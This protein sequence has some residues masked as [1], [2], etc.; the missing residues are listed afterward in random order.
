MYSKLTCKRI[1]LLVGI[2]LTTS[3]SKAQTSGAT[4]TPAPDKT[5]DYVRRGS[6]PTVGMGGAVGGPT[7]LF[8]IYDAKTLHQ[9]DFMVGLAYGNFHR[10]PGQASIGQTQ[11]T[12]NYG[13][14]EKVEI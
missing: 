5:I 10:D 1:F 9:K 6:A 2:C 11:V 14:R 12:F 13:L 7:G 3:V 4:P 8:T